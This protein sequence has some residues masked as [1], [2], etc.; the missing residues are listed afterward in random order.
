MMRDE[1]LAGVLARIKAPAGAHRR[2]HHVRSAL[3]L[4]QV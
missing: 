4:L 1:F 2:A 3:G